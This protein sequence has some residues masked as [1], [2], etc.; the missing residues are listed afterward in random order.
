MKKLPPKPI[1]AI[2]LVSFLIN[3]SSV[4][5]YSV[6]PLYLTKVLGVTALSLGIL[7]GTV[8]MLAWSSRIFSGVITDYFQKRKPVLLLAYIITSISRPIFAISN[9]V[10]LFF[11][12]RST[13]RISNGLQ[14]TA[15]DSLVG[16]LS[17]YGQRGSAYGLRQSLSLTGSLVGGILALIFLY[18]LSI[19]YKS[20]FLIATFP[21]ILAIFILVYFVNEPQKKTKNR[22]LSS[23]IKPIKQLFISSN[24]HY[25]KTIF[26]AS[27]YML[28][29][30][31]G[32]FAILHAE[33]I[34]KQDAI[35]PIL[36][37]SQNLG[38][39]LAAYPIGHYSDKGNRTKLLGYGFLLAI[40]SNL[41]F[42]FAHNAITILIA[43][44]LWGSQ[45]GITQSLFAARIA[46][47]T[48]SGLRGS[49]FGVYYLIMGIM[50]LLSNTMVG[51]GFDNLAHGKAFYIS[52]AF[53][54]LALIILKIQKSKYLKYQPDVSQ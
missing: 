30:Y 2:G 25:W 53:I 29:N 34:T 48:N 54:L 1:I 42:T 23:V 15:R 35:G 11:F 21:A 40:L 46:D 18:Y 7:E 19:S 47:S 5:V 33:Y 8:E 28:G 52:S 39:M 36:M 38:G 16:D 49:A 37:I 20:I 3:T 17:V 6:T 10:Y 50:I 13:D 41:C 9:S 4:I 44:L 43:S 24:K 22:K 14:A 51:W 45:M 26:L 31:S 32:F 12:A 27:L